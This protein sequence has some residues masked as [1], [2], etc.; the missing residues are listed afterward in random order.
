M[1][2]KAKP[3]A[4]DI[5]FADQP[6]REFKGMTLTQIA[7]PIGGIGA[8]NMC[9]NGIGGLQDFSICHRPSTSAMPDGHVT[10][11]AAFG[12]VHFTD[13][14]ITRLLEGPFPRTLIYNQGLKAQGLRMGGSEGFPRFRECSFKGEFPF[15][16]ATLTDERL[17]LKVVIRGFNPFTPGDVKNSAIPCA[18][19]EY[20]FE[21]VSNEICSFE[22]SYHLSHLAAG[23]RPEQAETS[24]N[25]VMPER[26][27]YFY[28]EEEANS[29]HFGSASLSL[30]GCKPQ[31]KGR[32]FRGG[33]FDAASVLWREISDGR[34]TPNDGTARGITRG[35]NGGSV[36]LPVSLA[37]GES[38]TVP[39]LITWYFPNVD[40]SF[41]LAQKETCCE[42]GACDCGTPQTN[43]HPYY[44]GQWDDA[45][46]VANYVHKHYT[47][48]RQRTQAFHDALFS[49][50]LPWYVKDAVSANLA[51]IK[52]PTVLLQENGNMWAWEGCFCDSGCC[53]GSCTHVW[54]YAQAFPLLFPSLERTLREQELERSMNEVG[55]VTFRSALP[56]GEPEHNYH[57]ASDG[58]LGGIMKVH[59]E[60]QVSGDT[61]WMEKLYPLVRRSINYCI[62]TWDPERK[63]VLVEPHHN[64][65][66]IEFWGPDG[67]CSS[68]YLG[69]LSAMAQMAEALGREKDAVTYHELAEKGARYL[70]EHLFNGEYY[71]QKVMTEGLRAYDVYLKEMMG[72]QDREDRPEEVQLLLDEGPKYQYGAGCISDGVLGH[73]LAEMCGVDSTQN[74]ANVAS[75][76]DAIFGYNFKHS[77]W[78][79]ANPQRPGYAL[80]DEPGLLLCSWPNGGKPSLPFVYSDEVWTGIEYQVASHLIMNG[81][82]EE[83]LSIVYAL[84]SR[85]DGLTR[86]PWNEYEC[87]N[88]Y[89]R[90]MA[91][92]S[93]LFALSGARYSA[94]E[95]SLTFAPKYRTDDYRVFFACGSAWGTLG[96]KDST[97]TV[98]LVEGELA[99]DHLKVV[100]DGQESSFTPQTVV[101]AGAA[102]SIEL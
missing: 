26:G 45:Q 95:K 100:I 101:R 44:A 5:L 6:T 83:G 13:S 49:S 42:P 18:I 12:L 87:G 99:I 55:H 97:L 74:R 57:A 25:E 19:L 8:G 33:W 30:I 15:G 23:A 71:E 102:W 47:S 84:R 3:Y 69:A 79:H 37:P 53:Y 64:T 86:N 9:L 50:T 67:M 77:L 11:H 27:V 31:I 73:W 14:K 7:M 93:L 91:S 32:W 48:L 34:F 63:G 65:Y 52:S 46:D 98:E 89:A 59:R 1:S 76:L 21:N 90:A 39:V 17:P 60:W 29:P 24:R 43:W 2:D 4:K 96:Y 80:G 41:G 88:Y 22:F 94:V 16:E 10:T 81:R 20:T 54:N 72:L 68:F 56:D 61:R 38:I 85:Y 70:D 36:M 35:R 82:V 92:Y 78:E 75:N 62:E 51:I 40:Y 58:Q 28:N 66:D